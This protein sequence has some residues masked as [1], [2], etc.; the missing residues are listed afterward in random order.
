MHVQCLQKH[1]FSHMCIKG[2][3]A[4]RPHYLFIYL[5]TSFFLSFFLYLLFYLFIYYFFFFFSLFISERK[6][7]LESHRFAAQSFNRI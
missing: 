7:K 6:K 2:R 3:R 4:D 1:I 5:F